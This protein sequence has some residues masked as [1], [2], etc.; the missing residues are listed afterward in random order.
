MAFADKL[1]IDAI[2]ELY[3]N[4]KNNTMS[5]FINKTSKFI[6]L[7]EEKGVDKISVGLTFSD[8]DDVDFVNAN[9]ADKAAA[10]I[11][12]LVKYVSN[13]ILKVKEHAKL[14]KFNREMTEIVK[15]EVDVIKQKCDLIEKLKEENE[16]VKEKTL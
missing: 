14:I 8:D 5:P 16:E 4:V 7:A 9:K 12:K 2:K 10:I 6:K 15:S 3:D 1:N 11:N 13:L